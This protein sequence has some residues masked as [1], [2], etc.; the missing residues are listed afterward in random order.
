[1]LKVS[2]VLAHTYNFS[3][4]KLSKKGC[5]ELKATLRDTARTRPGLHKKFVSHE[6]RMD[7]GSLGRKKRG[8][9]GISHKR[10]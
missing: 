9:G 5:S 7:T 2:Q 8:G 4:Q 6:L 3:T 10:L 1:M